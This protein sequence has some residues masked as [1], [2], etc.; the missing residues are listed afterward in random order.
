MI[1]CL[2]ITSNANLSRRRG[3]IYK[4]RSTLIFFLGINLMGCKILINIELEL[5]ICLLPEVHFC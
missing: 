5:T 1:F 3:Q 4:I 2:N